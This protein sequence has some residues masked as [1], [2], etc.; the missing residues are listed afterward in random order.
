MA[1]TRESGDLPSAMVTREYA[2]RG[3]P[4]GTAPSKMR[5]VHSGSQ[6]TSRV[7]RELS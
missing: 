2:G 5:K 3:A 1:L 6:V 4:A 7:L